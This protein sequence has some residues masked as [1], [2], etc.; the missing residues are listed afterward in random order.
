VKDS[1]TLLTGWRLIVETENLTVMDPNIERLRGLPL[2]RDLESIS[3]LTGG[4]SNASYKVIDSVGQYVARFGK[5][6]PFHQVDREREAHASRVAFRIG[7]SPEVIETYDGIMILKFIDGRTYSAADVSANLEQCLILVRKCHRDM[8]RMVTGQGAIFWVFQI[9]RDYAQSLMTAAH[10]MSSEIYGWME[11][12]TLLEDAQVPLPIVF[13]HH[14]LLPTNF[15]DDGQRL[16]LID[17]EYAAFGTAMFDLANLSSNSH[18]GTHNDD[19]LL[20]AYFDQPP[21]DA[22]RRAFEAMKVASALRE[23]MWGM[24]SELYLN[25]PGVNYASYAAG[26]LAQF[27]FMRSRYM[28][29]YL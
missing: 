25:A 1:G 28:E 6:Y 2:W 15:I 17:W 9:L 27:K 20:A 14:D 13:G 8:K 3:L 4:V 22:I 16:W 26:N 10:P 7:L 18:L 19:A 12:A 29:T 21:S 11:T 5:D 24:V 23:A